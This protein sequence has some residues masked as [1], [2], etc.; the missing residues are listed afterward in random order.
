MKNYQKSMSHQ[1]FSD[2][3][4]TNISCLYSASTVDSR[5]TSPVWMITLYHQIGFLV[6]LTH[7]FLSGSFSFLF[8]YEAVIQWHNSSH[9]AFATQVITVTSIEHVCIYD[10]RWAVMELL[11]QQMAKKCRR[12]EMH[13]TLNSS[14]SKHLMHGRSLKESSSGAF[15]LKCIL[16]DVIY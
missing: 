11:Q 5:W 4:E 7:E 10:F 3:F 15:P 13:R 1:T 12:L 6:Y 14:S 16:V 9:V 2:F 8:D